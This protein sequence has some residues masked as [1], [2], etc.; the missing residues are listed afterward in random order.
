MCADAPC[1]CNCPAGVNAKGFIQKVRFDNLGG[2]VRAIKRANVLA[3]SCARI[4]PTGESCARQCTSNKLIRPI[5]ISGLQRF[6]MDYEMRSGMID[7]ISP[8]HDK[9][10]VAVV[11]SG[12]AGLGAASELSLLGHPVT[13]FEADD[14]IGGMLRQCIPSFRLPMA[15]VD[16]EIEFIKKLGV[17]FST[18]HRIDDP[19]K[20]FSDGFAAVFIATGLSKSKPAD[21]FGSDKTGVYDALEFLKSA[22]RENPPDL[23]SR[24]LVI[25]GGD[26]ALDAARV[27]KRSGVESFILYR[28]TQGEMPAYEEE[29]DGAWKDGVEFYFRV[30]PRAVVGTDR[31]SG[32]RCVRIRWHQKMPGMKQ[33]YDVE[34]QEFVIGC[35][36]VIVAIGQTPGNSFG[37][38]TSTGDLIAVEKDTFMTSA[39]GI[40]AAG[41]VVEGGG[42]AARAVGTGKLAAAKI[43]E[44][45]MKGAR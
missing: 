7:P 11:G 4:C 40:F 23:G 43:H 28:R 8:V 16:F 10:P 24:V 30:L 29:I 13:V 38:R 31:V 18:N 39:K 33:G 34:G 25:G 21:F 44:Y 2:A 12:P 37:F 1:T 32:L 9:P 35:S 45:I 27:A 15:V 6:V 22:K 14:V 26:T 5:D 20:L 17:Q 36:S 3:A 42:T 19:Q 41:D